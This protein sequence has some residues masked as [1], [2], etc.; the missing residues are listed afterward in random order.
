MIPT[1]FVVAIPAVYELQVPPAPVFPDILM[2]TVV[3][4]T[5]NVLPAPTKFIAVIIPV[6]ILTPPDWI[7]I[8]SNPFD[9][10][11]IPVT[12]TPVSFVY[13]LMVFAPS[14]KSIPVFSVTLKRFSLPAA[15]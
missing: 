11:S 3:P 4:S 1:D 15:L 10:V 5:L 2:S 7:P 9:A 13:N 6:V 14:Y 8:A 12:S